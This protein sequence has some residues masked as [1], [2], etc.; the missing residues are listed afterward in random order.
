MGKK[1]SGRP[2]CVKSQQRGQ[3]LLRG[4]ENWTLRM[5]IRLTGDL[6]E[7]GF[8]GMMVAEGV[9]SVGRGD[10]RREHLEMTLSETLGMKVML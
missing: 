7:D 4:H 3:N 10:K 1:E 5:S 2:I 6:T 9:E 8:G